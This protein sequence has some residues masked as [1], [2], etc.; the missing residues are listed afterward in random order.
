MKPKEAYKEKQ[1]QWK[2]QKFEI[3][4]EWRKTNKLICGTKIGK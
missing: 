3:T 4:E 2:R 1:V